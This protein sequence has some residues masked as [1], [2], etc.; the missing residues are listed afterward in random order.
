MTT[1][2]HVTCPSPNACRSPN[3][4]AGIKRIVSTSR[5]YISFGLIR[6]SA[7]MLAE[8]ANCASSGFQEGEAWSSELLLLNL[9]CHR[10]AM[11]Q[12]A[13]LALAVWPCIAQARAKTTGV[14][15]SGFIS[16]ST[17]RGP[18]DRQGAHRRWW[19]NPLKNRRRYRR[20]LGEKQR[21]PLMQPGANRLVCRHSICD[22]KS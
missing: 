4:C 12:P 21:G 1:P 2:Q 3:H 19:K 11:V 14:K 18:R 8:N 17:D 9:R 7:E 5:K 6:R 22:G 15:T 20:R 13:D 16:G 10:I